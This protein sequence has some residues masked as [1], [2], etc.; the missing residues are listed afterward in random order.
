MVSSRACVMPASGVGDT[1][2]DE[3]AG[4]ETFTARCWSVCLASWDDGVAV[5]REMKG[6]HEFVESTGF[7][8][9]DILENLPLH[10]CTHTH[11]LHSKIPPLLWWS[12]NPLTPP[13]YHHS[14]LTKNIQCILMLQRSDER[15][16]V[17]RAE[18]IFRAADLEIGGMEEK[19]FYLFPRHC[20]RPAG[21]YIEGREKHGDID[22]PQAIIYGGANQTPQIR[23][24]PNNIW[25]FHLAIENYQWWFSSGILIH[26]RVRRIYWG[27]INHQQPPTMFVQPSVTGS[28]FGWF[29]S[30]LMM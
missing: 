15:K 25:Q 11:T 24:A 22:F 16:N 8:W 21:E 18:S 12:Q 19:I 14:H 6:E 30:V 28:L 20:I 5:Q 9:R 26:Q 17:W 13:P 29:G 1:D 10:T 27:F 7:F 23:E 3:K 4:E 2:Y